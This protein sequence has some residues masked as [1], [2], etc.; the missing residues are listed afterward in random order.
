MHTCKVCALCRAGPCRRHSH[1]RGR[2]TLTSAAGRSRSLGGRRLHVV[3]RRSSGE[4]GLKVADKVNDHRSSRGDRQAQS[5]L[6]VR[7]RT[8][9]PVK[10]P[11]DELCRRVTNDKQ[12]F[13]MAQPLIRPAPTTAPRPSAAY[14]SRTEWPVARRTA[15]PAEATRLSDCHCSFVFEHCEA[16]A[17]KQHAA[18]RAQAPSR[19]S[20]TDGASKEYARR[21]TLS[22]D[23]VFARA[24][25]PAAT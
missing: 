21:K 7:F 14:A 13:G 9:R 8:R 6:G 11:D 23:L 15:T 24:S 4:D 25:N 19:A 5:A 2:G 1:R 20:S 16:S 10:A 22:R 12:G 3:E 18:P 17:I